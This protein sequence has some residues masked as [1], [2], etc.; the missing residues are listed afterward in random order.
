MKK[1]SRRVVIEFVKSLGL[2][3]AEVTSV[4]INA[5]RVSFEMRDKLLVD[6]YEVV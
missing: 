4:H 5:T 2:N 1:I 3:P 6:D